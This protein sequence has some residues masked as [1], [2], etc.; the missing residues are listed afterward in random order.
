VIFGVGKAEYM[1]G[2]ESRAAGNGGRKILV[3]DDEQIILDLLK[4]VLTREGY[5]VSTVLCFDDAIT[6][7]RNGTYD[8]AIADV[9]LYC[10][11]GRELIRVI[12]RVSPGTAIVLMTGYA[13]DRIVRFAMEYAHGLLEKPFDL[14][15]LLA[16]VRAALEPRVDGARRSDAAPLSSPLRAGVQA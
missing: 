13:D 6:E 7:V 15:Q 9:G 2:D 12:G 3:V 8:L 10:S 5:Q 14:E 16:T 11:D 1:K 4:R